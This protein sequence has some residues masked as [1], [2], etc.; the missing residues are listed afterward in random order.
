VSIK[1]SPYADFRAV[2]ADSPSVAT[3]A[4][5]ELPRL[6]LDD[7]LRLCL[8]YAAPTAPGSIVPADRPLGLFIRRP[9]AEAG[10]A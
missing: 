8:V 10:A 9:E 5:L 3:A 4:A 6:G 1:G 7:A 2:Q